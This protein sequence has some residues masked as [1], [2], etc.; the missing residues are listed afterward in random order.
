MIKN[1]IFQGAGVR[2]IAEVGAASKLDEL[3]HLKGIERIGGSSAGAITSTLLSMRYTLPEIKAMIDQTDFSK[4]EDGGIFAYIEI[5]TKYGIHPGDV[6]LKYIQDKIQG[7]TGNPNSTFSDFA[8]KGYIDLYIFAANLNTQSV[9]RFSAK[10]TPNIPVSFAVRASMSIPIFF[11][12]FEIEKQIYVDAG[13]A[14][15]YPITTFDKEC[16][17]DETLGICFKSVPD[18]DNGLRFNQFPKFIKYLAETDRNA[19]EILINDSP[20]DICRSIQ[21]DGCGVSAIDFSGVASK[22]DILYSAGQQA[23]MNFF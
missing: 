8:S 2:I 17:I 1:L 4:F 9:K 5:I 12:A 15:N 20:D 6:F 13:T 18:D 16:N 23:V 19:Q 22:K 21:I 7:K 14:D 11:Q 3:G 10:E